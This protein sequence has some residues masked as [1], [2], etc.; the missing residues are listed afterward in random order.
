MVVRYD[1]DLVIFG[2]CLCV[3]QPPEC[4]KTGCQQKQRGKRYERDREWVPAQAHKLLQSLRKRTLG[5][6]G[7]R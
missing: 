3:R 6:I 4:K 1:D 7:S 5:L 2:H